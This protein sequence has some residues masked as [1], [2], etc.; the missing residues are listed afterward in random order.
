MMLN[1][2]GIYDINQSNIA[3]AK[4]EVLSTASSLVYALNKVCPQIK[5]ETETYDVFDTDPKPY[6]LHILN[7]ADGGP[8][9]VGL[10]S[11]ESSYHMVILDGI[12]SQNRVSIRDPWEA[13]RYFMRLEDFAGPP[14]AAWQGEC[15]WGRK[16]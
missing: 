16:S 9:I 6:I 11:P 14:G 13:T 12:D 7:Q 4:Q 8:C 2:R 1:S 10:K 5:W 3:A 15:V